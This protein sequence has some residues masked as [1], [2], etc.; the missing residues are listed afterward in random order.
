MRSLSQRTDLGA[1][2]AVSTLTAQ[3]WND[4]HPTSRV[5]LRHSKR[6]EASVYQGDGFVPISA[7]SPSANVPRKF[8]YSCPPAN[9]E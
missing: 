3:R 6:L 9:C 2:P 1:T 4:V 8:K 7:I 5:D